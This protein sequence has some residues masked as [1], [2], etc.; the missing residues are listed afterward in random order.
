ME[1]L[2]VLFLVVAIWFLFGNKKGNKKPRSTGNNHKTTPNAAE[3]ASI[4]Q[5]KPTPKQ[6]VA[7]EVRSMKDGNIPLLTIW[8]S[9]NDKMAALLDTADYDVDLVS[10]YGIAAE[11]IMDKVVDR[12]LKGIEYEKAG[13]EAAAIKLY[14]ANVA[15]EFDGS[16]PYERLR[17]IYTGKKK[18]KDAMRVCGAFID[19]KSINNPEMKQKMAKALNRLSELDSE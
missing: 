17:I 16:H 12:N 15:D 1:P 14:E 18:Y 9:L 5:K 13:K 19:N 2:L 11:S 3:Q 7:S 4:A 8:R 10:A 6:I